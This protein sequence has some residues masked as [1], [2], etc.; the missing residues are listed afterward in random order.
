L[1]R[2]ISFK[3]HAFIV[4]STSCFSTVV[5]H[6]LE[7]GW[8]VCRVQIYIYICTCMHPS[9]HISIEY[10]HSYIRM[11]ACHAIQNIHT[12]MES[13]HVC[14]QTDSRTCRPLDLGLHIDKPIYLHTYLDT[15]RHTHAY[16]HKRPAG[17]KTVLTKIEFFKNMCV[18]PQRGNYLCHWKSD[19]FGRPNLGVFWGNVVF[20]TVKHKFLLHFDRTK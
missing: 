17:S 18:L 14:I 6:A 16:T 9:I 1:I 11:Y 20:A 4:A 10:I 8:F 13:M 12:S 3:S 7:G 2:C 5:L 19:K 15:D